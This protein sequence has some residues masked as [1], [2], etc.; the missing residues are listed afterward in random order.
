MSSAGSVWYVGSFKLCCEMLLLL[1]V[2][3]SDMDCLLCG[4]LWSEHCWGGEGGNACACTCKHRFMVHAH[5]YAVQ[6]LLG[7]SIIHHLNCLTRT[8]AFLSKE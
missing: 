5:V 2:T 7:A 1:N 6:V 3:E 8:A 4:R